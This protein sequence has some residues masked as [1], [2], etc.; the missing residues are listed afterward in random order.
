MLQTIADGWQDNGVTLYANGHSVTGAMRDWM[1]TQHFFLGVPL[2][3]E[4]AVGAQET[5]QV[6]TFGVL[7]RESQN[8][9]FLAN[10]GVNLVEGKFDVIPPAAL[11]AVAPPKSGNALKLAR[12]QAWLGTKKLALYLGVWTVNYRAAQFEPVAAKLQAMGVDIAYVKF[13]E[14]GNL[15]YSGTQA[16]IKAV[17]ARHGVQVVPYWFCRPQCW[18]ADAQHLIQL[19]QTFGGVDL[20]VEEQWLNH[21][22]ELSKLIH[23]IRQ[24][25]PEAVIIADGYGDP[26]TAFN[27]AWPF[28]AIAEADCYQPQWYAGYWGAT[29]WAAWE[30]LLEKCDAECGVEFERVKLGWSF[31]IRPCVNAK[32]LTPAIASQVGHWAARFGAGLTVW[33]YTEAPGNVLGALKKGLQA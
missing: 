17:F 2:T 15:W 8:H 13:G 4:F 21:G 12:V 9:V 24:G 27:H 7:G 10:I 20:D 16:D 23:A 30:A 5:H 22:T 14:W 1:L 3:E 29:T 11:V 26:T 33:E 25:A 31:P 28:D 32:G 18:Q 19:A 6:F